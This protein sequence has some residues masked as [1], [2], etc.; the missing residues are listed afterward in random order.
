MRD[1]DLYHDNKEFIVIDRHNK[2][3][4]E[5]EKLRECIERIANKKW[6][7]EVQ[8]DARKTLEDINKL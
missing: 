4:Q 3:R 1:V 2:L 7:G 5:N 8:D 6:F